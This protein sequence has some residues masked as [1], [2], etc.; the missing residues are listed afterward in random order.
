M[1]KESTKINS[2]KGFSIEELAKSCRAKLNNANLRKNNLIENM[3]EKNQSLEP[4]VCLAPDLFLS[5]INLSEQ[6]FTHWAN[7]DFRE[8]DSA[9]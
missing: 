7:R 8:Y 4:E 9:A 6:Q 5:N 2:L 1:V 3:F